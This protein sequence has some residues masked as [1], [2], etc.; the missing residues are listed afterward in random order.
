MID[1]QEDRTVYEIADPQGGK[2]SVS[3][4]DPV[5][6]RRPRPGEFGF[7]ARF[8]WATLDE[9]G[10][11]ESITVYGGRGFDPARHWSKQKA[12]A[13][14]RTLRPESLHRMAK[15]RGGRKVTR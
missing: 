13:E 3:R 12:R 14:Y 9:D 4:G 7:R 8:M 1:Q 6:I 11:V 5:R 10:E 15:T 2:Y